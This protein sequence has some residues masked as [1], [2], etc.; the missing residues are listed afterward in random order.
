MKTKSTTIAPEH[1][2]GHGP[3]GGHPERFLSDPGPDSVI[4][5]YPANFDAVNNTGG[6]VNGFEMEADGISSADLTRIFGGVWTAGQP[7]VIRYCQGVAP[8]FPGGVYIRWMSPW[9]PN[10]Q[11]F[12]QGTPVPNGSLVN[13]ESCWTPI[14]RIPAS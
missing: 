13:G 14:P 3:T 8:D 10:T 1:T 9:D 2:Q 12:T 7:C 4:F 5:G 6:T 11:T